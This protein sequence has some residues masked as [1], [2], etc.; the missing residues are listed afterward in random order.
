GKH[1]VTYSLSSRLLERG[2]EGQSTT[3]LDLLLAQS[4]HLG[5]TPSQASI[6]SDLYGRA[7][8][9][10]PQ[11]WSMGLFSQT[12]LTLDAFFD[13]SESEFSQLNSDITV[14]VK[15]HVYMQLGHRH[16]RSGLVPQ[17][18][19]IWNPFSF[20]EVLSPQSEINFL[21]AGGG[22]RTPFGWTVGAKVYHDFATGQTPE[23]DVVG[24]YQNACK[25]WSLGLYYIQLAG[26]DEISERSQFNFVLTL[27]GV[28]A[29]PGVGTQILQTILGPLL[30]DEPGLPWAFQ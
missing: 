8:L 11:E 28:G 7:T 17:R 14:Q 25:C 1:L 3:W 26:T 30:T 12:A 24:L 23:W 6:F 21:T 16:T 4:Y 13:P 27:R 2:R 15:K 9:T 29:T 20:N 10:L 22:I 19:D 18:G 5:H